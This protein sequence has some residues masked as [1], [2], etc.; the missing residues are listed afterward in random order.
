MIGTSSSRSISSSGRLCPNAFGKST[1]V[2]RH[3]TCCCHRTKY[4]CDVFLPSL[5]WLSSASFPGY[6]YSLQYCLLKTIVASNVAKV[7]QFIMVH[8]SYSI[9]HVYGTFETGSMSRRKRKHIYWQLFLVGFKLYKSERIDALHTGAH[10]TMMPYL[11]VPTT[12]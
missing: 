10:N 2:L 5:S 1:P 9:T 6:N 11:R 7:F 8:L 4:N 12:Q 3:S